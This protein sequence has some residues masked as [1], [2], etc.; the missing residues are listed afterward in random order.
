MADRWQ[1]DLTIKYTVYGILIGLFFPILSFIIHAVSGTIS[2]TLGGIRQLHHLFPG[3]YLTDILILA[4]GLT[5]YFL[6]RLVWSYKKNINHLLSR[7]KEL[8]GKT[9]DFI[10]KL[11]NNELDAEIH[12]NNGYISLQE[13]LLHLRNYLKNNIHEETKRKTE[14]FQRSWMSEGLAKFGDILRRDVDNMEEF[15]YNLISNLVKYLNANQGG[16]FLVEV[17]DKGEPY[18]EMKACYAYDRRKF[19]DKVI[20][21]GEGI[22]G[23][24]ALEKQSVYMTDIP[25]NYL[26]ITSGL[27]HSNPK[28]LLLVPL[29]IQDDVFGIVE[30]AS[31]H[32]IQSHEIELVEKVAESIAI[33]I[34]SV[35]SNVRTAELLKESQQQA[36]ILAAQE[37]KNRQSMEELRETQEQAAKQAERFISFTNSVN[38]TLIRAEYNTDGILLYANTRF[39]RKLGYFSNSE[40]EGKHISMFLD[41]KDRDWFDEIWNRLSEGGKHYEGYMKH[42]TK[43]GQDLW[44]MSTYTCVRKDDGSVDKILFL[45]IDTTE[46]KKQSLDYEG[47]IE[48]INRLNI[49]AEF[50]PD[51]KFIN[52][53]KIFIDTLKYTMNELE[54]M[55]VFDFI[56]KKELENFNEIWENVT[57]G[58]PY[59]GQIKAFTKYED[60]K[61][62][63]AAYT[64]VNDM[65][66]EVAKVIYLGNEITH[67]KHMEIES[68]K[69]TDQLRLHEEKLKLNEIEL[70]KKLEQSREELEYQYREALKDRD[71]FE[72]S[73]DALKDIVLTIDQAGHILY[74]NK[75]GEK[76]WNVRLNQV[77]G[78]NATVLFPGYPDGYDSFIVS[79]LSPE[80]TRITGEIKHVK[81]PRARGKWTEVEML[82]SMAE[83]AREVSYTAFIRT[84]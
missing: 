48:A 63:R 24:C 31:F 42:M 55:S 34:S 5:G 77:R 17:N 73:L 38:H 84:G 78:K 69:Q 79:F 15:A 82:L 51:G 75:S 66:G 81:L 64:A 58:I 2:L 39:L 21:W 61:W 72:Q 23:T 65:Y 18:F 59:Q 12:L 20:E 32:P 67:E 1:T 30:L 27:G 57:K 33:T 44:T 49:K 53:N 74:I 28:N 8:T 80:S 3:Q 76:F 52:C 9:K 43:T 35:K 37:E 56:D 10:N 47:Q 6:S 40:V 50:A 60:E 16:F 4:G 70:K 54:E 11:T 22:V 26:A 7:D 41:D 19:T 62:F 36:E 71:R 83:T 45:A 68:R 29:M 13:S 14:D 25:E 46:Q